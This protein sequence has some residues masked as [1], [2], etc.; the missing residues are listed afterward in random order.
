MMYGDHMGAGGWTLSIL[1]SLLLIVLVVLAIAWLVRSQNAGASTRP[2]SD[3][4]GS[5][6]DLLD[7]RLVSGEIDEDEY[8]RLRKAL[9]EAPAPSQS[10]DQP[11]HAQ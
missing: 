6:R 11:A 1:V 8:Q 5:A 9:I 10:P 2:R 4:R 7:R 3:E